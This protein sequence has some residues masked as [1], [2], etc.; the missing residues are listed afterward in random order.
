MSFGSEILQMKKQV[1]EQEPEK[2]IW[3]PECG[4]PLEWKE[5]TAHCRYCGW[6][7]REMA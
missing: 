3:C 2:R 7:S 6:S 1:E 5:G 4:Y